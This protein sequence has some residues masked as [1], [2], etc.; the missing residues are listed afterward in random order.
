[1]AADN[2]EK[3]Q[4]TS[5]TGRSDAAA[6]ASA[7][8]GQ[9][10]GWLIELL[11]VFELKGSCQ[12]KPQAVQLHSLEIMGEGG[13]GAREK[14]SLC[15]ER[16]SFYFF[17]IKQKRKKRSHYLTGPWIRRLEGSKLEEEKRVGLTS[18]GAESG[19]KYSDNNKN[20]AWIDLSVK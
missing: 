4:E 13:G 17:L 15:F 14:S 6:W 8:K 12:T 10:P 20:R 19:I 7:R 16:K 18:H 9:R 2:S 5:W 3:E 11:A 1:M